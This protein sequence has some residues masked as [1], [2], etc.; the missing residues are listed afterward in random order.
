M[1]Q[2]GHTPFADAA[3]D[4]VGQRPC[5]ITTVPV[6]VTLAAPCWEQYTGPVFPAGV[7][8]VGLRGVSYSTTCGIMQN[9]FSVDPSCFR[10]SKNLGG[11]PSVSAFLTGALRHW[12]TGTSHSEQSSC[13]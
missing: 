1:V 12:C 13:M 2:P 6:R 4:S 5:Y 8:L 10:H 3:R 7:Y 9:S 11:S